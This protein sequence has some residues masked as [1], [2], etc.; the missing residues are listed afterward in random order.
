MLC[1]YSFG[2]TNRPSTANN[3]TIF[4]DSA[5]TKSIPVYTIQELQPLLSKTNEKTYFVNCWATRRVPC[6]RE[7]QHILAF[8]QNHP[9]IEIILVSMGF[10]KEIETDSY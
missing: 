7:F 3:L 5:N 10:P 1:F 4:E 2:Y 9:E 6:V 8:S